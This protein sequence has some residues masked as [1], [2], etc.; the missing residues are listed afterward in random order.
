[1][2]DEGLYPVTDDLG[3]GATVRGF[4]QGQRL[5]DRYV[6]QRI[7]GRGGM[8]VVWLAMDEKL[9]RNVAMKF[10]PEL[11]KLDSAALDDLKRETRRSLEL[12]HAHIVRIYDFVDDRS[13]ERRRA[14]DRKNVV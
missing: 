1:M 14:Q 2:G 7:L 6:L 10:L 12:T 5:F 4:V 3:L 11:I 9:E 8:G 13:E